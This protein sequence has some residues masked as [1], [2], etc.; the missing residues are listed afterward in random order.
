MKIA[1]AQIAFGKRIEKR[2]FARVGIARKH[3]FHFWP[4]AEKLSAYLGVPVFDC[5][6]KQ[7]KKYIESGNFTFTAKGGC[8]LSEITISFCILEV[9]NAPKAFIALSTSPF[10]SAPG[11]IG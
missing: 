2:G 11:I 5:P 7:L 3:Y 1:R 8:A 6:P 9:K 4:D 10:K